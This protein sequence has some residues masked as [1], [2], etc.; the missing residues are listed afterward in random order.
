MGWE[1]HDLYGNHHDGGIHHDVTEAIL[2]C[3]FA[4]ALVAAEKSLD[5]VGGSGLLGYLFAGLVFGPQLFDIVPQVDA[6]RV[7]GRIG[8]LLGP[9]GTGTFGIPSAASC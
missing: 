7:L 6:V 9:G 2:F 4:V 1:I 8:A 3:V 5:Y